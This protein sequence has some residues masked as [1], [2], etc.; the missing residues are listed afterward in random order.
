MKLS[1][2]KVGDRI[3]LTKDDYTFTGIAA[4]NEKGE[5]RIG[6]PSKGGSDAYIL[7]EKFEKIWDKIEKLNSEKQ[8]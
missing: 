1:E 5:L 3:R 4:L 7:N 2:I 8:K 6:K